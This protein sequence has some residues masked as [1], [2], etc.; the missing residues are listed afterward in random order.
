MLS[1]SFALLHDAGAC[2][3][4]YRNL[5]QALGGITAYGRETPITLLQVLD[6]NGLDDA[7]WALRACGDEALLFAHKLT[8]RYAVHVE[9]LGPPEAVACNTVTRRYLDGEATAEELAA[10]WA[11][12]GAAA[13]ATAGAA[14]WAA[15][16]AAR[17]PE[18]ATWAA[19]A[20]ALAARAAAGADER[21]WQEQTLREML[22]EVTP[23]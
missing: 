9:H 14:A 15:V 10:V 4:R 3:A 16:W 18:A 7:L 23:C 6:S 1:T 17:R 20:A 12:A 5:A 19:R 11:T 13:W 22:D 21:A 2:E 8:W